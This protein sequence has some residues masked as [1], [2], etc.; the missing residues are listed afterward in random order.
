[1]D[2]NQTFV[3]RNGSDNEEGELEIKMVNNIVQQFRKDNPSFIGYKRIINSYRW[4]STSKVGLDAERAL[5]LYNKYPNLISGFDMV[6]EED[7]GYSLLF[8]LEDFA[9][10]AAQNI[11]L[12][13]FFHTAETNWPDDLLTSIHADDPVAT[14][15][16]I[17]DAIILGAKRVGHGIGYLDHPYLM[18]ILKKRKIAIEANPVS[19]QM[20]GYVPDQRHH[21]AITYLRYGIPVVLGADDPATFG[22]NE[23]TL[24]WYEAFMAW[25][26]Y[27]GDRRHLATNSLQYSSLSASEKKTNGEVENCMGYFYYGNEI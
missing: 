14:M 11:S 18:E 23:F 22:Y 16:N 3:P 17:Y 25:G 13:Y 2:A 27:L 6:S 5:R 10:L 7:K 1:L 20:L 12:P 21:P 9:K 4:K 15:E 8:F 19:N 26:L 24:D